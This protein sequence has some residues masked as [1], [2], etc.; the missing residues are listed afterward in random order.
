MNTHFTGVTQTLA[1]RKEEKTT[2]PVNISLEILYFW[3]N[4]LNSSITPV[5]THSKPPIYEIKL[6]N[7]FL[8]SLISLW[9]ILLIYFIFFFKRIFR[10]I[11]HIYS[12]FFLD[13]LSQKVCILLILF[14]K[15]I[16]PYNR[17]LNLGKGTN[18]HIEF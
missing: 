8:N 1:T 4:S 11:R 18:V 12:L 5:I 3:K 2:S 7:I 16:V 17:N 15:K 13:G 6:M 9:K 10:K 14:I